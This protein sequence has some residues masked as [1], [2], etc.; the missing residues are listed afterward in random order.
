M[1]SV[2]V[3]NSFSDKAFIIF[4]VPQE[5]NLGPLLFLFYLNDMA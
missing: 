4:G 5:P 2:H 3:E 1:F